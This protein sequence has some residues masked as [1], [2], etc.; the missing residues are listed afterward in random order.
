MDVISIAVKKRQ[1]IVRVPELGLGPPLLGRMGPVRR[2]L[3]GL[4]GQ[5]GGI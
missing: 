3:P 4:A 2:I 5:Y 1:G